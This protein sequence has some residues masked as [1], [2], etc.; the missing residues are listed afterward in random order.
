[1]RKPRKGTGTARHTTKKCTLI[2]R[3]PV[4]CKRIKPL[5]WTHPDCD[6]DGNV[7]RKP[8]SLIGASNVKKI[9]YTAKEKAYL[10]KKRSREETQELR[11]S[12]RMEPRV[13]P[14]GGLCIGKVLDA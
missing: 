12:Q 14:F 2:K 10:A 6:A 4:I 3:K 13:V 7:I 11:H 9:D 1:M 8:E 5:D